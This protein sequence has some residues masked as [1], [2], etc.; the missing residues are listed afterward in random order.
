VPH[1]RGKVNDQAIGPHW[2]SY[3]VSALCLDAERRQQQNKADSHARSS[4]FQYL[5]FNSF[6]FLSLACSVIIARHQ[7][8]G[9]QCM[10][11][12][13]TLCRLALLL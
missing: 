12:L 11:V 3:P 9:F 7:L 2:Y 4:L 13:L 10:N 1:Q 6:S 8:P 5:I